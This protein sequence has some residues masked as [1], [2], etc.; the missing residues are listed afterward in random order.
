MASRHASSAAAEEYVKQAQDRRERRER[1]VP[2]GPNDISWRFSACIDSHFGAQ[3]RDS[4]LCSKDPMD[5]QSA[6]VQPSYGTG[7]LFLALQALKRQ[8]TIIMS[9]R[10]S[11]FPAFAAA[12]PTLT[13][14][15]R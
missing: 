10:D 3:D 13:R 6:K 1:T 4:F 8:P 7:R 11:S 14:A 9:L 2:E 5:I 12:F 15:A